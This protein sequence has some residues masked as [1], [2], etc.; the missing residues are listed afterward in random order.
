MATHEGLT[1]S[2]VTICISTVL[3]AGF[4]VLTTES[5]KQELFG[6]VAAYAAVLVVCMETTGS[7]VTTVNAS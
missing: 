1:V 7:A 6:A 5:S 4:V 3:F 2:L